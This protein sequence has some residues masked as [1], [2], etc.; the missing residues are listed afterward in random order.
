MQV[1]STINIDESELEAT[2]IRAGGPGGQ[3]VN[4]VSTAVQLRFNAMSSPS[5]SQSVKDRLKSIA[6]RRLLATGEILIEAKR[7]RSQER[8]RADARARLAALID[9]A[10]RPPVKRKATRVPASQ[11]RKRLDDKRHR[12]QLKSMRGRPTD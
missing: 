7:Y 3:N 9:R 12:S 4:K 10:S 11:K 5:L 1:N 6:G 8:N 2:F